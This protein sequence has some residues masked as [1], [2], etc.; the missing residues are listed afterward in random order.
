[1]AKGRRDYGILGSIRMFSSVGTTQTSS[2]VALGAAFSKLGMQ[3]VTAASSA[4]VQLQVSLTGGG[5]SEWRTV[6]TWATSS[7][8]TSGDI[9]FNI[10]QPV[11]FVR[12][13][14]INTATTGPTSAWISA[15]N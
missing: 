11:T 4:A 3:V 2:G 1:M 6:D 15:S 14:L 7:G 12:T 10:D 9:I 5:S 8:D 13:V